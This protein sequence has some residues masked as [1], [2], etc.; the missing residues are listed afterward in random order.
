MPVSF[1]WYHADVVIY[2]A[3]HGDITLQDTQQTDVIMLDM[4][5][6]SQAAHVHFLY[7]ATHLDNLPAV[8][9]LRSMQYPFHRRSQLAVIIGM[10]GGLRIVAQAASLMFRAKV[11]YVNTIAEG[12]AWL[13]SQ[14]AAAQGMSYQAPESLA[15]Y[16]STES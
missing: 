5:N 1:S 14:D 6:S 2:V 10:K 16:A 7:D 13:V 9:R 8:T 3:L 12:V 15:L 11:R 4:L